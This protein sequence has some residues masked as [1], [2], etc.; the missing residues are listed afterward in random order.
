MLKKLVLMA[1]VLLVLPFAFASTMTLTPIVDQISPYDTAKFTLTIN[2][3][4]TN[5]KFVLSYTDL[6]WSVQTDPLTDY[7]TGLFVGA[8]SSYSTTLLANPLVETERVF[9]RHSL[10]IRARSE[11][12]GEQL[13]SIINIDVRRDLIKY[14]LNIKV[15]F[16]LPEEI[17]PVKTNSVKVRLE[18]SNLLDITNL[19]LTLK[20]KLFDKKTTVDLGPKS[21]KIVDFPV[22]I[23][24]SVA[25]QNDSATLTV[26]RGAEEIS[27]QSK[28]YSVVP[29]GKFVSK[30]SVAEKPLGEEMT[31]T[32]TGTGNSE[33]TET[34]LIE[35]GDAV[36]RLFSSTEPETQVTFIDGNAYYTAKLTLAP[37]ESKSFIVR[38]SYIPVIVV[39]VVL[40]V[41]AI[42]Y[43]A[44]R[45]P[46]IVAKEAREIAV[47]EGGITKLGVLIKMKNRG[48]R[49]LKKVRIIERIPN[50]ARVQIKESETLKPSKTYSYADGMVMEYDLG[51]MDKGEIRFIS[52]H[53]K[54]KLAIV[55]GIRLKPVIVQYDDGKKVYSNPVDVYTP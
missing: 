42:L 29:Y 3:N 6:D 12:T 36:K 11:N 33:Q 45:T 14:P 44:F 13:S 49:E 30:T 34:I 38:T 19:T 18:N 48:R 47:E 2:N 51:K 35:A 37:D 32:Y 10:E 50:I 7:T 41:L 39:L 5:D 17:F 43:F 23:D 53:L 20:S 24:K 1:I 8:G 54:T 9:K 25:P 15:D 46:V 22:I 27:K 28:P 40:I 55:G 21:E 16:M 31:V 4:G 52:Y 26:T